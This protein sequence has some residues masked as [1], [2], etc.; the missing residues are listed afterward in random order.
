MMGPGCNADVMENIEFEFFAYGD[1]VTPLQITLPSLS[2]ESNFSS[3]TVTFQI[4]WLDNP[5]G[6]LP[7]GLSLNDQNELADSEVFYDPSG[8]TQYMCFMD[9][10]QGY[11]VSI[12]IPIDNDSDFYNSAG[13]NYLYLHAGTVVFLP[14]TNGNYITVTYN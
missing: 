5:T 8:V 9:D 7:I 11:Y 14:D 6:D 2:T 12:D 3:I 4:G 10:P 13:T 1:G